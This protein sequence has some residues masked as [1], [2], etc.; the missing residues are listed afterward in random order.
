MSTRAGRFTNVWMNFSLLF[1]SRFKVNLKQ[2]KKVFVKTLRLTRFFRFFKVYFLFVFI[3]VKEKVVYTRLEIDFANLWKL[4]T[5]Q[6]WYSVSNITLQ[7]QMNNLTANNWWLLDGNRFVSNL[8]KQK[9][10][11]V[12]NSAPDGIW[13]LAY[14]WEKKTLFEANKVIFFLFK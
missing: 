4:I 13:Q 9:N 11:P 5:I 1:I 12:Y 2:S 3:F 6:K 8:N 14:M 10:S 7:K